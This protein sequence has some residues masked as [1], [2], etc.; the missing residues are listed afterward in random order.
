MV[1]SIPPA[2]ARSGTYNAASVAIEGDHAPKASMISD[3][4]AA[5]VLASYATQPAPPPLADPHLGRRPAADPPPRRVGRWRRR[6]VRTVLHNAAVASSSRWLDQQVT[7]LL[8][9]LSEFGLVVPAEQAALLITER[10]DSVAAQMR[11]S[12][13]TARGYIDPIRLAESLAASLQ[14][15][16]PGVDMFEQPR[17]TS[18]PTPLLGRCV[19]GLA[20]AIT[21]RIATETPPTATTSI[22]NLAG[23]LSALGQFT[24]NSNDTDWELARIRVPRAFLRRMI[25]NLQAA[26]DIAETAQTAPG[27]LASNGADGATALAQA[28]RRDADRLRA[29]ETEPT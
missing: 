14:D 24:T 7:A 20:E 25:R 1:R 22:G 17:D 27:E 28:F 11:V 12:P 2:H 26:A 3:S 4:L 13:H 9:Q 18:I 5:A 21:L 16:L 19:A 23:C 8:G 6:R 10:V 15:E 29:I